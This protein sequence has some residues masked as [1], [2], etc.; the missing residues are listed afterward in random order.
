MANI[1]VRHYAF[2]KKYIT[3]TIYNVV[4]ES[5]KVWMRYLS[6]HNN[7]FLQ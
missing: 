2:A 7:L 6:K 4:S 5:A 1:N 3:I